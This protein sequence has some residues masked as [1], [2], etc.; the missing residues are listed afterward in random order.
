[1][2]RHSLLRLFVAAFVALGVVPTCAMEL[3]IFQSERS[4]VVESY[5]EQDHM[6]MLTLPGGGEMGIPKDLVKVH[7]PG[8]IPPKDL[9]RPEEQ[10]PET[11]PYRDLIARY[12]QEYQMDWKLVAALI[13]VESNF[14]PNAV[15]P[16]GAQGLMQLMPST[17]KEEG[18]KDPF[19]PKE[20]LRG[21]IHYL[22]KMLDAFQGDLELTL[23]AYNAG[24]GKV[25]A[26]GAI[27]PYAETK[28][29]VYKILALY[30]TL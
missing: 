3:V 5:A 8:Y 9:A 19:D 1:M 12:C 18:V 22:R 4:L 25:Q 15:S 10:L 26:Y 14:N 30:P 2:R 16:K 24:I 6:V 7:Y 11:L 28:L 17:Q 27:P 23:A 20:N 13:R 21:G 29:Y